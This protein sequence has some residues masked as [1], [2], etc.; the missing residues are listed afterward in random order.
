MERKVIGLMHYRKGPNKVLFFGILQPIRDALK[1]LSKEIVKLRGSK[2]L[3]FLLGPLISIF[4]MLLSWFFYDF[5]FSCFPLSLKLFILFSLMGL[6]S[7]GFILTSWGSNS[8]YSLLGGYRAVAQI[9][10]YEVCMIIF[11]I[12]FVFLSKAYLI[13]SLK[14]LQES[15]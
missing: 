15:Y 1:L 12:V 9:I 8:K 14:L 2:L 7:Y 5:V 10:S 4:L 3:I 6:T 11:F 13:S